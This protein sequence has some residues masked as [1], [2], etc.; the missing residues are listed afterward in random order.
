MWPKGAV[1]VVPPE[2]VPVTVANALPP[3]EL[4]LTVPLKVPIE[5]GLKRTVTVWLWPAPR[6]KEPPEA[7]LKGALV[8]ALPIRV[9]PPVLLT[10]K[11]PSVE[12]PTGTLPKFRE[13]GVTDKTG[14]VPLD[15][16]ETA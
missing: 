8:L 12:L 10:V 4:K 9:P 7:M 13:V 11:V 14:L 1:L 16:L 5:V 2:P 3:L 15:T 6:L